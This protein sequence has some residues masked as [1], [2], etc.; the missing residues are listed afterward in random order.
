MEITTL[1]KQGFLA[2]VIA[3]IVN[4]FIYFIAKASGGVSNT[5]LLPGGKPLGI[6]PV[7]FSSVIPAILAALLLFTLGKFTSDP[8]R[9]VTIIAAIVLLVSFGGPFGI[10]GLPFGTRFTLALMHLVAGGVIIYFL[11]K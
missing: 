7:I 11:R 4:V 8:I 6:A 10:P 2:G 9:I 3:A 1:L 5:V